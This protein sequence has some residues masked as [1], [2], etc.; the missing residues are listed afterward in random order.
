MLARARRHPHIIETGRE[1]FRC[2][3]PGRAGGTTVVTESFDLSR[4]P[5]EARQATE[6]GTVWIEAMTKT[7]ERL[8]R[9]WTPAEAAHGR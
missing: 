1:S 2:E 3:P 6:D 9:L 5:E 7:L 4:S 8:E